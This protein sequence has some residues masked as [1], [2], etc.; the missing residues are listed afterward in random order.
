MTK[1]ISDAGLTVSSVGADNRFV[2]ASG[3]AAAINGAFGTPLVSYVVNGHAERAPAADISV[4]GN[5]PVS[6]RQSPD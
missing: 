2:S 3:S 1:W 5:S 6:S 4:P